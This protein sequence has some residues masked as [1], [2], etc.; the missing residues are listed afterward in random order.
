MRGDRPAP[1]IRA[2]EGTP[3]TKTQ[4]LATDICLKSW[5]QPPT[6]YTCYSALPTS[7]NCSAVEQNTQRRCH[8][9]HSTGRALLRKRVGVGLLHASRSR[10]LGAGILKQIFV[11]QLL[12]LHFLLRSPQMSELRTNKTCHC[13]PVRPTSCRCLRVFCCST[14]AAWAVA[15]EVAASCA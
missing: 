15:H 7:A 14:C 9:E 1:D 10:E 11:L 13:E 4:I 12:L 3:R 2:H 5:Y 6:R 8:R